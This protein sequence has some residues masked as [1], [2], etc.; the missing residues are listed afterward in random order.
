MQ[1]KRL[2]NYIYVLL[3]INF[4]NSHLTKLSKDRKIQISL[5]N[6]IYILRSLL[7]FVNDN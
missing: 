6:V 7:S 4:T 3:K 1:S 2:L 5:K